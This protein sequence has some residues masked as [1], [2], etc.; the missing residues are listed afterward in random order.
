MAKVDD[1]FKESEKLLK[2]LEKKIQRDIED[3]ADV[4]NEVVATID[5]LENP[6]M[7]NIL[8]KRYI[9]YEDWTRIVDEM[10]LSDKTVYRLHG[11]ALLLIQNLIDSEK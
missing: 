5:K 11:K 10:C 4:K 3:L 9:H 8:Y 2:D 1:G 7:I 6:D